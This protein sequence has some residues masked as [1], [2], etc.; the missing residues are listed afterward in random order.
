MLLALL[1]FFTCHSARAAVLV[2]WVGEGGRMYVMYGM[3]VRSIGLVR[4]GRHVIKRRKL[5]QIN[6][7]Q[8]EAN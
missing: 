7:S 4:T 6:E 1:N 8:M 2:G 3:Y 5:K